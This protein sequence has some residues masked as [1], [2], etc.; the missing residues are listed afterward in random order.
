VIVPLIIGHAV[1]TL[2]VTDH[3]LTLCHQS[4]YAW[5]ILDDQDLYKHTHDGSDKENH[6]GCESLQVLHGGADLQERPLTRDGD[7]LTAWSVHDACHFAI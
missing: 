2:R 5:P 6:Q 4:G 3:D 1:E 7:Q